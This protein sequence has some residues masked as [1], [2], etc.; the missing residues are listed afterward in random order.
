MSGA[1]IR[2]AGFANRSIIP[3]LLRRIR[4]RTAVANLRGSVEALADLLD[5]QREPLGGVG[6][7]L[8]GESFSLSGGYGECGIGS[9]SIG[10]SEGDAV[11]EHELLQGIHLIAELLDRIEIG[12]RHG[13]FLPAVAEEG[14][15]G[16]EPAHRL[17]G[18]GQ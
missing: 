16:G 1:Q 18:G 6:A 9:G 13:L 15:Q 11:R 14:R 2:D 17:C 5:Q 8:T 7:T 12:I 10:R 3:L 4:L